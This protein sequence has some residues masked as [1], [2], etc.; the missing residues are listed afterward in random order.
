[1]EVCKHVGIDFQVYICF[2]ELRTIYASIYR[3]CDSSKTH[4]GR[5]IHYII[6]SVVVVDYNST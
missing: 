5:Y 3:Q 1:M 4:F 2:D 6:V